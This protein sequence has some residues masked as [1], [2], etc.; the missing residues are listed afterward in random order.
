MLGAGV[1]ASIARAWI[2][3]RRRG[4]SAPTALFGRVVER[5]TRVPGR[6]SRRRLMAAARASSTA[7]PATTTRSRCCSPRRARARPARDHDGRRQRRRST[8][9]RRTRARL[10][11][12]RHPRRAGRRRRRRARSP[13]ARDRRRRARRV[14]RSTAP[15]CPSPT[16][17]STRGRRT[18]LIAD[19]AAASPRAGHARRDRAADERRDRCSTRHPDLAGALREIVVM[20][21]STERGNRTPYAEFNIWVDPEAAEQRVRERR[22]GDDGRPQP[23]PPGAR[24]AAR[25][26]SACAR[27]AATLA[28]VVAGWIDVLR[29][30]LPRALGLRRAAG[31]RRLRR[32]ARDR[33]DARP[34]RRARSSRSRPR[35]AWTRGATVVDLHGRLATRRTRASRSTSTPSA[36]GTS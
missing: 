19:V 4:R 23:H 29:L 16:S 10:H 32:R 35:A 36:S 5:L 14:R 13:R 25:S 3:R 18:E 33:P 6:A 7:T 8:R 31:P 20:G 28:R 15:S 21:G 27:S 11:A 2:A 9:S 17:R 30:D 1:I 22:A 24:D 34:L 26:S 12:R